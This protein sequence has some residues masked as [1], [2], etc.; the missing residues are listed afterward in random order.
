MNPRTT[1]TGTALVYTCEECHT[2]SR[3]PGGCGLC[4]EEMTGMRFM[5]IEDGKAQLC[6]CDPECTCTSAD[7]DDPSL[8]SC[9]EP[10]TEVDL[11]GKYLCACGITCPSCTSLADEPGVCECGHEMKRIE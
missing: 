10:L 11:Q 6:T 2:L 1:E 7:A 9:G 3:D 4:G 5:G 8:C